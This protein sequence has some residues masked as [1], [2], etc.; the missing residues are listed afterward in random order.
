MR[1]K[2][3]KKLLAVML[4][5]SIFT[6][7]QSKEQKFSDRF[8][9]P[10]DTVFEVIMY[11]KKESQFDKAFAYIK[12]R[13]EYYN[14]LFDKYHDVD[15]MN[16][17]KTINDQAGMAP[18]EVDPDLFQLIETSIAYHQQYSDK[19]N[20]ALGP[21]LEVWHDCRESGT[22]D[23]PELATLEAKNAYTDLSQV[24][25]DSEKQTVYLAE[26]EMSLDVGAIA[27]GYACELVKQ[28]LLEQGYDDFLISAGGNVISHGKRAVQASSSE[29]SGYLP[30]CLDY[31]TI[32]IQSP[33]DGAYQGISQIAAITLQ[34]T[35][36]VT[37]GD[38]QRYYIG[39]DGVSYHHLIDPDT[40]YPTYYFRSVSILTEDSGLA[41]FLSSAT[42]LMP[43]EEGKEMI[44]GLDGVEAVW[45][46][47]DGTITYT[48]GLVE[49]ENCHF[50][51]ET[52]E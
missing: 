13:F 35:S 5:L 23:V 14:D 39:N 25:L 37:S 38:Y 17:L 32:S 31:Y 20:I 2:W 16:N 24:I 1:M 15:G 41:D 6:G 46:L 33:G 18:V 30:A 49:G 27:K 47:N 48:S 12:E 40:L 34:E 10:F 4:G 45:L 52:V 7:C 43:L 28:D 9:G 42:F 51:V 26:K 44:E 36:V 19:V 8:M 21:V 50:Y 11:E 3:M 29:L 22:G